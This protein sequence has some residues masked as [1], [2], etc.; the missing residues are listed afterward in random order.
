MTSKALICPGCSDHDSLRRSHLRLTDI[1]FR[2]IGM[3]SYR[4]LNCY[5]RFHAW[6]RVHVQGQTKEMQGTA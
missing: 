2:L 4:C 3:R 1:P 5:K 6:R